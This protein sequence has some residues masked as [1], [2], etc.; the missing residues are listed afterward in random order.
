MRGYI[1]IIAVLR[2]ISAGNEEC[3]FANV[4]VGHLDAIVFG[5]VF[6]IFGKS[7]TDIRQFPAFGA[8]RK[9]QADECVESDTAGAEERAIVGCTAIEI[10]DALFVDDLQCFAGIHRDSEM[11]GKPVARTDGDDAE[12]CAATDQFPGYFVAGAVAADS[13]HA[14]DLFCHCLTGQFR[15]MSRVSGIYDVDFEPV[16]VERFTNQFRQIFFRPCS[17]NGIDDC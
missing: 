9:F 10:D 5:V 17:R 11:A 15:S 16:V 7:L 8:L 13:D 2:G 6:Q 1:G 12:G 14:V 3:L 4:S